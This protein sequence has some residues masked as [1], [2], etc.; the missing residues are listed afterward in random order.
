[1][2]MKF[3]FE[4]VYQ[5]SCPKTNFWLNSKAKMPN[6]TNSKRKPEPIITLDQNDPSGADG[7]DL[8]PIRRYNLWMLTG[9]NSFKH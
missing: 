3:D 1:M 2:L 9:V 4:H 6:C 5:E 8:I 7:T